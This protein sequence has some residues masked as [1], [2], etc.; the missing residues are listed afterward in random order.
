MVV[1]GGRMTKKTNRSKKSNLF[2]RIA[3]SAVGAALVFLAALHMALFFFG[4][5][6][7]A[8]VST[9]RVGGAD[10]GKPAGQRYEW[11][12]DYTFR[13]ENGI[14]HSGHTTRR[15]GDLS[16]QT[17]STVYYFPFAPFLNALAGD[18]K[19]GIAQL[20]MAAAGV[21]L[22]FVMNRKQRRPVRPANS[23]RPPAE[24]GDYDDSVEE[25]FHQDDP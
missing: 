6:A 8:R 7:A 5:T 23:N 25:L 24:P 21:F 12:L 10:D 22:L 2:W 13:D 9:R 20:L 3:V 15:G 14:L 17:D 11:S 4:E 18:A 19:P 16:V 1:S